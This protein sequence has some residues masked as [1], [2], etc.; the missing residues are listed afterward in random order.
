VDAP[1]IVSRSEQRQSGALDDAAARSSHA[2]QQPMRGEIKGK[3]VVKLLY[4][5]SAAKL[6]CMNIN[7]M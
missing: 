6:I 4:I 7:Q 3:P 1:L 5:G 2:G